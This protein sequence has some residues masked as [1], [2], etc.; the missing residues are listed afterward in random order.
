MTSLTSEPESALQSQLSELAE[1]VESQLSNGDRQAAVA[2]CDAMLQ[3]NGRYNQAHMLM[4][5]AMMP[6]ENYGRLLSRMH[7]HLAPKTYAEIG[8]ATGA[9][10]AFA[11]A[12]TRCVGIDPCPRVTADI[13][14]RVRLYPTTS[15]DFFE[16][17]NLLE[18]LGGGP[19]D[20][21]F[22]DGLHL[23]EQALRDFINMEKHAT[24]NT[25]VLIH[26]CYPPTE[27]S[28]ERDRAMAYW[29]G[30]VW[31]LIPC[32]IK[33]RPDLAV[34]VI[35]TMPSGVGL[36]TGLDASSTVLDTDFDAIVAEFMA[37]EYAVLEQDRDA[38]LNTMANSWPEVE[39]RLA[40]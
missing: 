14:A 40:S 33:C 27:L 12:D 29:C 35:P 31:R 19:L 30:D 8:V 1:Q 26:D 2:S 15:D 5:R 38:V 32:L 34:S 4:A 10:M 24:P 22:I 13:K 7:Q 25:V 3:L 20:L 16:R 17:Y 28:A 9:S 23:F 37:L 6:G 39:A 21:A 11:G 18:E 36:V